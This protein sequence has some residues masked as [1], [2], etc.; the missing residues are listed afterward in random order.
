MLAV[1]IFVLCLCFRVKM[2]TA[3]R[4]SLMIGVAFYGI[5]LVIGG[6]MGVFSPL[7]AAFI[8]R[9]GIQ[10]TVTDIG[11]SSASSITWA[12]PAAGLFIPVGILVNIVMLILK[13]THTV[14]VDI[15][16]YWVWGFSGAIIGTM[17]G[18]VV[19]GMIAF[20]VTEVIILVIAD[21]TAPAIHDYFG[22][23]GI[24]IP[25]G[26]AAPF[27]PLAWALNKLFDLIPGLN[28]IKLDSQTIIKRVGVFGEPVFMGFVIGI[29][30][31]ALAGYDFAGILSTGVTLS[32]VMVILPRMTK[33]IMEALGPVSTAIGDK[34]KKR[35]PGE[36]FNI[37]LD[38]AILAGN[39]DAIAVSFL[40]IPVAIILA[41]VLP[42][43]RLLPFA[44]LAGISFVV[45]MTLP[46]YKGN[47]LRTFLGGIAIVVICL[48]IGTAMAPAFTELAST[49]GVA[50][51]EGSTGVM[52]FLSGTS[53]ITYIMVLLAGLFM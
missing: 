23:E 50:I 1:I 41:M 17:T 25:H 15:W 11:W 29:A 40:L 26:N 31:S 2:D 22:L 46:M 37:G 21:K 28:K 13:K 49:S 8:E 32:A 20:I 10:L 24:S 5:N 45:A 52:S 42:G 19:I 6:M 18:N 27:V 53:P 51:P 3:I 47:V 30:L 39:P 7:T 16:N 14:D 33:M 35:F 9:T 12:W 38:V 36:E 34:L 48:Y 4:S 44:D 43:N